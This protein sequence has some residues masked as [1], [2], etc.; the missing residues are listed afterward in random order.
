MEFHE[1]SENSKGR[2][3]FLERDGT[4][5]AAIFTRGTQIFAPNLKLCKIIM[6]KGQRVLSNSTS[7]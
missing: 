5:N 2:L 7:G 1:D 3:R 4:L 6:V